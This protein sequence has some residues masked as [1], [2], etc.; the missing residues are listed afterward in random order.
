M[1]GFIFAEGDR[2]NKGVERNGWG[3]LILGIL[4]SLL[5]VF[6]VI[7]K[8]YFAA[9]E[10][11]PQFSFGYLGYQALRSINTWSWIVFFLFGGLESLNFRSS[12]LDYCREAVLPFY[13]LH[14]TVILAVGSWVIHWDLGVGFKY[15][16]IC[17]I[18]FLLIMAIYEGV[19]KRTMPLWFLFRLKPR[20]ISVL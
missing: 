10:K 17:G 3:S 5:L 4:T 9:W 16:I 12:I 6:L 7:G 14:Q 13:I 11:N 1:I 2:F 18:S 20:R 19:V 15:L 8:G